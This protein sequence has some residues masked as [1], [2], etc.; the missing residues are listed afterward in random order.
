MIKH[1]LLASCVFACFSHSNIAQA[2]SK[3]FA[4][5]IKVNHVISQN[6]PNATSRYFIQLRGTPAALLNSG[7]SAKKQF[8]PQSVQVQQQFQKLETIQNQFLQ[9]VSQTIGHQPTIFYQYKTAFNG[10]SLELAPKEAK[11]LLALPNVL[12][13]I[14]QIPYELHTDVGPE[15]IG[16]KKVW[17]DSNHLNAKGEGITIGI[18][19]SGIN[20]DHPSFAT[21]GDDEYQHINPNGENSYLGDCVEHSEYCNDKLIG[22]FSYPSITD[23]FGDTRPAIGIDYNGHGSHVASTVAGNILRDIP[24]YKHGNTEQSSGFPIDGTNITE[25]SGVAPHANIISFQVC[26]PIGGCDPDA[27]VKAVED[28]IENNVNVINMSIGPSGEGPLPWN[29]ALDLAFLAANN[30]GIFVALSAG[31][32]GSS[33]STVG[34]LAPWTTIVAN[35]SHGRT[36]EKTITGADDSLNPLAAINGIGGVENPVSAEVIYAGDIDANRKTCNFFSFRNYPEIKDKIILCDRGGSSLFTKARN[37]ERHG[38]LGI[39]IRNVAD[40]NTA[41]YSIPYPIPGIQ[42]SEQDG[43]NL[44]EWMNNETTATLMINAGTTVIDNS[45]ANIINAS[46]SRG[47]YSQYPELLVPHIAAPGT[48]IYAAYTDEQPF[49]S[50]PSPSNYSFLTGTSMA[51]PHIAGA[52]ALM[53]QVHPDW[54]VAEIQSAMMMTASTSMKKEDRTTTADLWDRGAGMI[55]VDKAVNAGLLLNITN[56]QYLAANPESGGMIPSLNS[57]YLINGECAGSCTWTREFKA[58]AD[59]DWQFSM[60]GRNFNIDSIT[61]EPE[62]ISVKK[63]DV[64]SVDIT[65]TFKSF[66]KD[67]WLDTSINIK[68]TG[69]L[70]TLTLPMRF[71]PLVAVVPEKINQAYYWSEAG[72]DLESYIFRRPQ[73]ILFTNTPL[74]KAISEELQASQDSNTA[75]PFDDIAD[76]IAY[77]TLDVTDEMTGDIEFYIADT[78]SEDIDLFVGIDSNNDNKPQEVELICAST[79]PGNGDEKCIIDSENTGQYWVMVW[80]FKASSLD[81]DKIR[82]DIVNMANSILPM[83]VIPSSKRTPFESLPVTINWQGMLEDKSNYYSYVEV[84]ERNTNEDT[85]VSLGTTQMIVQQQGQPFEILG[86]IENISANDTI[87]LM[88]NIVDNPLNQEIKYQFDIELHESF[89][90]AEDIDGVNANGNKIQMTINQAA[91]AKSMSIALPIAMTTPTS[92]DFIHRF[93]ASSSKSDQ[94]WNQ[95]LKQHNA[96]L[97]PELEITASSQ[98]LTA[99]DTLTLTAN[100]TD[101]NQDEL[102]YSWTQTGGVSLLSEIKDAQTISLEIPSLEREV[103]LSFMVSVTDGEFTRQQSI[104]VTASPTTTNSGGT[105]S[106]LLFL[107]IPVIL[108]RFKP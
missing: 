39:I 62:T 57:A 86:N 58:T 53:K 22:I 87:P 69:T 56:E 99:G 43:I 80:N 81:I 89:Q 103:S 13:V 84:F 60:Q 93:N 38:A 21:T 24:F 96:N 75:T 51:S 31:N 85:L 27:M 70:D 45:Q 49:H 101:A 68:P 8:Q 78:S 7:V 42:I 34:H 10:F 94:T 91:M 17:N 102:Q 50:A 12:K 23:N 98:S 106:W 28:A 5:D 71:K 100:G 107:L 19:D 40:S 54:S 105:T 76:G 79:L 26:A 15:L 90:L 47:P 2:N 61:F 1:T 72:F 66:S 30:A 65:A 29:N 46:S 95:E 48:D 92:G 44:Y 67:E 37:V 88:L 32:S 33:A 108:V 25:L 73:Q 41:L 59:A 4:F 16:A 74:V 36:I 20:P 9:H 64:V 77:F 3:P 97:A 52:A 82:V 14:R 11:K 6:A 104:T 18:I 35:A 83:N 55:Q 63:G